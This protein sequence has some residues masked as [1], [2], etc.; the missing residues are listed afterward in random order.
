MT[1]KRNTAPAENSRQHLSRILR[2]SVNQ[3]TR[4]ASASCPIF[5]AISA[6]LA[7][8]GCGAVVYKT[9]ISTEVGHALREALAKIYVSA[10]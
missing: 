4:K 8:S 2:E 5:G 3:Y 1:K 6:D 9:I 7:D 10:V